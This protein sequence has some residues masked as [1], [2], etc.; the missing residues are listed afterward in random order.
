MW[1]EPEDRSIEEPVDPAQDED[2][3]LGPDQDDDTEGHSLSVIMGVNR[4]AK[5]E[6]ERA[7]A[8]R[9]D[10]D[11]LPPLTRHWPRLKEDRKR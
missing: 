5:S 4:M 11:E 7:R 6:A 10:Q 9:A 2:Q 1:K 8:R 3:P